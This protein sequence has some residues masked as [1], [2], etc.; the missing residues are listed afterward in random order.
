M[1]CISL[2]F[3]FGLLMMVACIPF[4][5]VSWLFE[6]D[7]PFFHGLTY[8]AGF[9]TLAFFAWI[10]K[11]LFAEEDV[12]ANAAVVTTWQEA[13]RSARDFMRANGHPDARLTPAGPDGG[14]DVVSAEAIAQVK[15]YASPIGEP[16]IV[17]LAGTT[18]RRQHQGR[19]AIFFA[20]SGYTPKATQ[21]A[22]ELGITLY[23]LRGGHRWDRVH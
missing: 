20:S 12:P 15:F 8:G 18:M 4:E 13:E 21:T 17:Q 23:Q 2:V 6:F 14:V 9:L 22:R 19:Q 3:A 5:L 7:F 1:G 10:A 16:A 11:A